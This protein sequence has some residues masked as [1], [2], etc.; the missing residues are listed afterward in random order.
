MTAPTRS[1]PSGDRWLI[2]FASAFGLAGFALALPL[3]RTLVEAPE[4][5]V[6]HD[7]GRGGTVA[8][9]VGLIVVVPALLGLAASG[10]GRVRWALVALLGAVAVAGVAQPVSGSS[11]LFAGLVVAGG[12]GLALA[13]QG[14]PAVRA[15]LSYLVVVPLLLAAWSVGPSRV[16]AYLRS[17]EAATVAT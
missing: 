3:V 5:F 1:A 14:R 9:L 11:A 2:R 6:A 15:T 10:S 7:L 17:G 16:G 13:D 4:F 8:Y 12:L